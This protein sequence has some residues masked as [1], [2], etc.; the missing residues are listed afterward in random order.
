MSKPDVYITRRVALFG[1]TFDPIHIGH[2][3]IAEWVQQELDLNTVVFIPNLKHPFDKRPDISSAR[4]RLK[5]VELAIK[6]FLGF[7]VSDF[8]I[9][10]GDVSYSIET[11]EYFEKLWP[12][13]RLLFLIGGDNLAEFNR[14]KRYQDIL[15]KVQLVVYNRKQSKVPDY[16]RASNILFLSPPLIDVSSSLIRQRIKQ[17]KAVKS[18]LPNSV[19]EYVQ[20]HGLYR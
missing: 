2:L 1:G 15:K 9:R 4:H 11:I 14:W 3:I 17:G 13:A 12:D 10:K 7:E 20:K 18:L 16:L 19:W 6:P 8:E 5:M